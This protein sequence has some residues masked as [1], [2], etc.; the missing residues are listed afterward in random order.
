MADPH[1]RIEHAVEE[2]D[3]AKV[4]TVRIPRPSP[5]LSRTPG[6]IRWTARPLGADTAAVIK[7]WLG[8]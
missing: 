5:R 3:D 7:D 8:A 1:P 4:G 6:E 2:V